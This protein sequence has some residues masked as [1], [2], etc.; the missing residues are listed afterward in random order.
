M[1]GGQPV[2]T[3][4][5]SALPTAPGVPAPCGD[6]DEH[7]G[8]GTDRGVE[9][10]ARAIAT[11]EKGVPT[12]SSSHR[13][14][15][16]SEM[17][18]QRSRRPPPAPRRSSRAATL[19]RCQMAFLALVALV[20]ASCV[21]LAISRNDEKTYALAWRLIGEFFVDVTGSR[22]KARHPRDLPVLEVAK[23]VPS[24]PSSGVSNSSRYG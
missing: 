19:C 20:S 8:N 23:S 3:Q 18:L 13:R 16:S 15:P 21:A 1:Q 7:F 4:P 2:F 22:R 11:N 12:D 14:R 6:E 5:W 9:V 24:L 17:T 10:T